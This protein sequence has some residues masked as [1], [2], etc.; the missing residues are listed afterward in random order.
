MDSGG[1]RYGVRYTLVDR[2]ARPV[3]SLDLPDDWPSKDELELKTVDF[4]QEKGPLLATGTREFTVLFAR[5]G[6][7]VTFSIDPMT[8]SKWRVAE[9][10]RRPF[11]PPADQHWLTTLQERTAA[12]LGTIVLRQRDAE[13]PLRD[14]RDF[15]V[16]DHGRFGFLRRDP[17]ATRF[18]LLDDQG[19]LVREVALQPELGAD[20]SAWLAWCGESRWVVVWSRHQPPESTAAWL[21]AETGTITTIE[22]FSAQVIEAL[23]GRRDG[24]FVALE[25]TETRLE[26]GRAVSVGTSLV[27]FDATGRSQWRVGEMLLADDD[28]AVTPSGRVAVIGPVGGVVQVFASDGSLEQTIGLEKAFGRNPSYPSGI[29]ADVEGGLLCDDFGSGT[30]LVRLRADGTLRTA[31]AAHYADGRPTGRLYRVR[32]DRDGRLWGTDGE[33]LLRLDESG[34]VDQIVGP[35]PNSRELGRIASV[36]V[37]AADRIFAVD[38]R[39]GTLHAFA[40]GGQPE[41]V[42]AVEPGEVSRQLSLP[43]VTVASDGRVCVDV[44]EVGE[45]HH[46]CF[47]S[48]GQSIPSIE[49][50]GVR[51]GRGEPEPRTW[52]FQARSGGFWV[53]DWTHFSLLDPEGRLLRRIEKRANGGWLRE[54][55]SLKPGSDGGVVAI[56]GSGS[57]S[58]S[59]WSLDVYD[60]LGS[61]R[62]AF[63]MPVEALSHFV[64]YDGHRLALWHDGAVAVFGVDGMPLGQ[65]RLAVDGR[66]LKDLPLYFAAG[67]RELWVFE[68]DGAALHRFSL[69]WSSPPSPQGHR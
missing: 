15:E 5:L 31:L 51:F 36:A 59:G 28:V 54:Q 13:S 21:D 38:Q 9:T 65:L 26:T 42:F 23:A 2:A 63:D 57:F 16:D 30:P 35:A 45:P 20:A 19:D 41:R 44:G 18:V 22:A 69:A 17:D 4:A 61:P 8:G 27:A 11:E 64:A 68:A 6:Q 67:G 53:E 39:T 48:D 29:S 40:P 37:D 62:A 49:W 52:W 3:W 56:H 43:D 25:R 55:V 47:E 32:I 33:A 50:P 58:S 46:L 12:H 66:V 14:V 7:A 1:N 60:E 34:A 10:G 24:G